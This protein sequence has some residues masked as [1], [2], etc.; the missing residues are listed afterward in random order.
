MANGAA[1]AKF[2][3]MLSGQGVSEE[4]ITA[5]KEKKD[6]LKLAPEKTVI[7]APFPGIG[8]GGQ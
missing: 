6:V 4:T 2:F 7:K 8:G 3:E 5:L 1:K